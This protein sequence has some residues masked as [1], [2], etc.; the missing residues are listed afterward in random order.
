LREWWGVREG[1]VGFSEDCDMEVGDR[2]Q[3][4]EKTEKLVMI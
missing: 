3:C 2:F 4:M 1:S